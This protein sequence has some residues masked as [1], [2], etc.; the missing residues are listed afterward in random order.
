MSTY[1]LEKPKY[2]DE[3]MRSIWEGQT[4]KPDQI[5]LVKDGPLTQELDSVI[6]KW[7]HVIGCSKLV[8]VTNEKNKGLALS[9]NDGIKVAKG[10]LIAR[11]DTDDIS[12]P[13]RFEI[14]EKFMEDHPEVD[15]LGGSLQEFN[16]EGSL[17]Y[18]RTF[19]ATLE[20]IKATIHRSSPLGHPSVMFR[21]RFFDEGFSYK[22]T[23]HICE[24][25]VLWF[26]ALCAGKII[27]NTPEVLIKFRRN[28]SM[29]H[30]RSK[31]K[32]WSEFKA[33]NNGIYRLYGVFTTRYVF[34]VIRLLFRLLP[35]KCI[36][37]IY[38]LGKLRNMLSK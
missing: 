36:N 34:S 8:I 31:E 32:A 13:N 1:H 4:R 28:D 10:D 16:D 26:D 2:L 25:I 19:P 38:K 18:V 29:M 20:R 5:V 7:K 21:K 24:D 9:L 37:Y 17:H 35:S 15:I 22:N 14:Q 11:M 3:A 27:H 33:Y 30:R 6:E 12:L 23:Y